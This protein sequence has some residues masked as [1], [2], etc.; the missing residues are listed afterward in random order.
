MKKTLL[1]SAFACTAFIAKAQDVKTN[2]VPDAVKQSFSKL[3]PNIVDVK[4]EMEKENYEAKFKQNKEKTDLLFTPA[5]K[6]IQTETKLSSAN[7]L[8]AAITATLKKDFSG[9]EFE[10]TEKVITAE[11]KELYKVEA[12]MKEKE[13]ELLFDAAGTLVMKTEEP[14][15]KK[16]EHSKK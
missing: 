7:D 4:W 14:E 15:K 11:G 16:E 9:Y 2:L 13:Y 6:L 10:D 5:G 8:P 3:Y 1:I 12:E